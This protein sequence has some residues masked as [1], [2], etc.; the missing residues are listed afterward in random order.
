[1]LGVLLPDCRCR[2]R[3]HSSRRGSSGHL[4]ATPRRRRRHRAPGAQSRLHG[5]LR[6][7]EP[8]LWLSRTDPPPGLGSRQQAEAT[9]RD[10]RSSRIH[11]SPAESER[12]R[13]RE[14]ERQRG[15]ERAS[16]GAALGGCEHLVR[17]GGGGTAEGKEKGAS[18]G[19]QNPDWNPPEGREGGREGRK[20]GA[21]VSREGSQGHPR[22]ASPAPAPKRKGGEGQEVAPS[23]AASP[24]P[25]SLQTF[26]L[27]TGERP[28]FSPAAAAWEHLALPRKTHLRRWERHRTSTSSTLRAWAGGVEWGAGKEPPL[29]KPRGA[30]PGPLPLPPQGPRARS[31][32]PP[33]PPPPPPPDS[34]PALVWSR[35]CQSPAFHVVDKRPP[36]S[37][38]LGPTPR[39]SPGP[40]PLPQREGDITGRTR[41]VSGTPSRQDGEGGAAEPGSDKEVGQR[42]GRNPR[43]PLSTPRHAAAA[44]RHKGAKQAE[45]NTAD[46]GTTRAEKEAPGEMRAA[47]TRGHGHAPDRSKSYEM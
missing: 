32:R 4:G 39:R 6:A 24:A 29:G 11:P 41:G 27:E 37:R 40:P 22:G 3:G 10:T 34:S 45:N 7:S 9:E 31:S 13:L 21:T 28:V 30:L 19:T 42:R 36:R 25:P 33:P 38:C 16:E 35:A 44:E 26:T 43:G 2:R 14:R 15:S 20:E 18:E 5:R 17:G 23:L 47:D 12:L 8:C 46:S 1:M